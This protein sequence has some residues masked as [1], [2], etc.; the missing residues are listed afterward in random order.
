MLND[1][2]YDHE[3]AKYWVSASTFIDISSLFENG[4]HCFMWFAPP[5]V[6]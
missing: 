6:D 4:K 5:L 2:M 1:L 3:G